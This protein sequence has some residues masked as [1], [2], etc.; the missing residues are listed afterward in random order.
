MELEGIGGGFVIG[1]RRTRG[2]WGATQ[3]LSPIHFLAI[4]SE[5]ALGLFREEHESTTR[6][7]QQGAYVGPLCDHH[8][9]IE[10]EAVAVDILFFGGGGGDVASPG[11]GVVLLPILVPV[12]IPH[13]D[14]R[15]SQ[16]PHRSIAFVSAWTG[17]LQLVA[18][19][20]TLLVV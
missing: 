2:C 17:R 20:Y 13:D 12:L 4:I 19:R 11:E 14:L 7:T 3:I 18:L 16:T 1:S 6:L 8:R 5:F 15:N 10:D 9:V